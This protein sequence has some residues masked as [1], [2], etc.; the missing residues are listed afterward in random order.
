MDI[1]WSVWQ[2]LRNSVSVWQSVQI[3]RTFRHIAIRLLPL[4]IVTCVLGIWFYLIDHLLVESSTFNR[5]VLWSIW[6]SLCMI[7]LYLVGALVQAR[8]S[9]KITSTVRNNRG[10]SYVI[11][12]SFY[13]I[14]LSITYILQTGLVNFVLWIILP[15]SWS[16]PI[17]TV[18]S[19]ISV[20]WASTFSACEIALITKGKNLLE[21]IYFLETNWAFGLG[22]GLWLSILYHCVPQAIALCIWQYALLLMMLHTVRTSKTDLPAVSRNPGRLEFPN[23]LKIFYGAKWAAMF[24]IRF[25]IFII[26]W[27]GAIRYPELSGTQQ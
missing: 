2:G 13:G 3:S 14:V 26:D 17:T 20:A 4:Y 7:P 22:Y 27:I 18:L 1:S 8:Y 25:S 23:R 12:E 9:S 21:R 15:L 6:N 5:I 24:F 16:R 19:I 11:S 10:W